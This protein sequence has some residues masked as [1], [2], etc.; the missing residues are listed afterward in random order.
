VEDVGLASSDDDDDDSWLELSEDGTQ[1]LKFTWEDDEKKNVET[2]DLSDE[3]QESF[4]GVIDSLVA[5]GNAGEGPAPMTRRRRN[6]D[7]FKRT[8][9]D[10]PCK[11][12][13]TDRGSRKNCR[14]PGFTCG[15][16]ILFHYMVGYRCTD[17]V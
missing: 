13:G 3:E 6:A 8:C 2:K 1:L 14:G 9:F 10:V 16:C 7:L 17:D 15:E 12:F 11:V 4:E 5:R